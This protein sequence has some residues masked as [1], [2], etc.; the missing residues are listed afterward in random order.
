MN[1]KDKLQDDTLDLSMS[2]L[3]EVPV[4]DIA[5]V[6]KASHLDLSNN[7]LVSL[8]RTFVTL[9]HIVKLDLSKNQLTELPENFGDMRQLKYLDLYSN[10]IS[11]LPLSLAELKN[12]KWLDLKGNPLSPGV[13]SVA[14]LCSNSKEC[15]ACARKVVAYL[16]DVKRSIDEEKQR[17]I[18]AVAAVGSEKDTAPV[19]KD[20]KKKKKKSENKDNKSRVDKENAGGPKP[21]QQKT[22]GHTATSKL[23]SRMKSSSGSALETDG[24]TAR[25]CKNLVR[26]IFWLTALSALVVLAYVTLPLFDKQRSDSISDYLEVQSGQ[27]VKYYQQIGTKYLEKLIDS[28]ILWNDDLQTIA[29]DF[30]TKYLTPDSSR[31][32]L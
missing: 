22:N 23:K 20:A 8:P 19:K 15:Q 1:L 21:E 28:I 13:A 24:T 32:D 5:A 6:R 31:S 26:L 11:R 14:G 27:P 10:Q 7:R 16:T 2:D 12:L 25:L 3:Q 17:R 30:Y 29:R 4:K 18:E 9:T